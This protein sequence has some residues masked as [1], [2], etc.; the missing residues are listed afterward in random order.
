[1][2]QSV[3]V[4]GLVVGV[5]VCTIAFCADPVQWSQTFGGP[6]YDG[7]ESVQQTTDGG[8]IVAGYTASFGAGGYDCYLIKTDGDGK[9]VFGKAR[10]F[11]IQKGTE[12]VEEAEVPYTSEEYYQK[13][14]EYNLKMVL[15]VLETPKGKRWYVISAN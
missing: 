6:S 9:F 7:G 3:M 4:P 12:P 11:P 2:G 1:M 13:N 8:Y 15:G 5:A 14:G 10:T